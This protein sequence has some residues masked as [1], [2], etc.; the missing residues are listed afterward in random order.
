MP[1]QRLGR[2]AQVNFKHLTDV[3]SGRNAQGVQHDLQ[4]ST[5]GQERHILLRQY[6]RH[7]TLVAVTACHLVADGDLSLLRD[8]NA[9]HHVNARAELVVVFLGEYLHIHDGTSLAVRHAQ[10]GIA[11]LARLFAEYR[12]QQTLFS[13]QLGFALGRYLTY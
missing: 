11:H 10:R 5:V 1:A 13:G 12:A 3:H 4:R 7:N 6:A 9:H 8:V 2:A